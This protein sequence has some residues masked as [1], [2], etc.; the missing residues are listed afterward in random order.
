[1]PFNLSPSKM[2]T[3]IVN[4][5]KL[6]THAS[7]LVVII[8]ITPEH[9]FLCTVIGSILCKPKGGEPLDVTAKTLMTS[10]RTNRI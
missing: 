3:V 6:F 10:S 5:I 8:L 7:Q 9:L 4:S 1:M 2:T